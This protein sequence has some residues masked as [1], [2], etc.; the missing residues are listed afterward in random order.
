M[1]S[2]QLVWIHPLYI[3][4]YK[5]CGQIKLSYILTDF[6][7]R[8]CMDS[9]QLYSATGNALLE[10]SMCFMNQEYLPRKINHFLLFGRPHLC[11][12]SSLKRHTG[13]RWRHL[14][15]QYLPHL[16]M[17]KRIYLN[18]VI[19]M[20]ITMYPQMM[21]WSAQLLLSQLLKPAPSHQ[22]PLDSS[23]V[24]LL[25]LQLQEQRHCI[26]LRKYP[27]AVNGSE[28]CREK[29]ISERANLIL[30]KRC[31]AGCQVQTNIG[32]LKDMEEGWITCIRNAYI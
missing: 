2:H 5:R 27:S 8:L 21:L 25:T 26:I 14:E 24:R 17:S 23:K 6:W 1:G 3:V 4:P 7:H 10:V 15:I 9:L 11:I 32:W 18:P 30:Q 31:T 28:T 12:E 20:W 19:T 16:L 29:D 22:S 13:D